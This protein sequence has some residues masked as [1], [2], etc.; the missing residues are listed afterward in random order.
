MVVK[1]SYP[2]RRPG[3]SAYQSEGGPS[4][5]SD[6]LLVLNVLMCPGLAFEPVREA[7]SRSSWALARR[8]RGERDTCSV[9]TGGEGEC[10]FDRLNRCWCFDLRL[11]EILGNRYKLEGWITAFGLLRTVLRI[12]LQDLAAHL[13]PAYYCLAHGFQ[14]R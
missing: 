3:P 13:C 9:G 2:T 11:K 14:L 6:Q 7:C 12:L 5:F 10:R 1:S 8:K 4:L